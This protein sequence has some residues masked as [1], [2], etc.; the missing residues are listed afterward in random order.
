MPKAN[1]WL[2]SPYS[3]AVL[4]SLLALLL[5]FLLA[6]LLR[7]NAPL[8]I[9]FMPVMFS[10]WYGGLK[11]GLLATALSALIST[12]FFVQPEFTVVSVV[13]ILRFRS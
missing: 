10:A 9:F 1:R 5:R 7:E 13:L 6:P 2:V 12:Y 11:P 8:L 4:A 3:I